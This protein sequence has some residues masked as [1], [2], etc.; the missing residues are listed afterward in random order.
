MIQGQNLLLLKIP[1]YGNVLKQNARARHQRK[2]TKRFKPYPC[3]ELIQRD[4]TN[5]DIRWIKDESLEELENIPEPEI[6]AAMIIENL[7]D[8]LEQFRSIQKTLHARARMAT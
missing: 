5:L 8:A 1:R 4:K 6:L 2:E 7:E 3:K